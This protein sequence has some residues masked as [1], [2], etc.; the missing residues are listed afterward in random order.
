MTQQARPEFHVRERWSY[1]TPAGFEQSRIV[2][3]AVF[4]FEQLEP[5]VACAVTDAPRLLPD[6][7]LEIVT[8]PF[9]PMTAGALQQTVIEQDGLGDLPPGFAPAFREWQ[10]DPRGLAAFTVPFEGRLDH[11]IAREMA[12]IVKRAVV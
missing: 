8:I 11:L 3:G 1:R 5:V 9:L 10:D 6:G 4:R 2:I 7:T 12:A